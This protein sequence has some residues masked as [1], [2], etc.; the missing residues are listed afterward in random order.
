[1]DHRLNLGGQRL[2]SQ[3]VGILPIVNAYLDRLTP[4]LHHAADVAF[5]W[6]QPAAESAS[7]AT[8]SLTIHQLE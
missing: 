8:G 4:C 5:S 1:M 2:G 6:Q 3:R 7:P